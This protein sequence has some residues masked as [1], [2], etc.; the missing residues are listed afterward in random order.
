MSAIVLL[1]KARIG[2]LTAEMAKVPAGDARV[3]RSPE[4]RSGTQVTK[5][6]ALAAEG[7]SRKDAAECEKIA[8]LVPRLFLRIALDRRSLRRFRPAWL[9]E[10]LHHRQLLLVALLRR[11]L[12]SHAHAAYAPRPAAATVDGRACV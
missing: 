12:C 9:R 2:E 5:R 10:A 6:D 4:S 8:A 3:G 11:L 1:A 7:L